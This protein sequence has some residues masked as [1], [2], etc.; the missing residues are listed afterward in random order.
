LSVDSL[1][2]YQSS[3][4]FERIAKRTIVNELFGNGNYYF[5]RPFAGT[6]IEIAAFIFIARFDENPNGITKL[7]LA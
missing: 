6:L 5:V 2:L 4:G 7:R 3:D 1:E